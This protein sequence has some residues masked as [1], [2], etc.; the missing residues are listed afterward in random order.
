MNR[1]KKKKTTTV[2]CPILIDN[3][4]NYRKIFFVMFKNANE[5][6]FFILLKNVFKFVQKFLQRGFW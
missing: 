5:D 3:I 1:V 6:F 4:E 2:I